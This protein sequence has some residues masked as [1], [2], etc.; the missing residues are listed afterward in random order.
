[1]PSVPSVPVSWGE[2]L[3]KVSI[4][5][6]KRERLPAG[7]GLLNVE[8][9]HALLGA[10]ARE[11]LPREGIA[12]LFEQLRR[13]NRTLWDVEDALR[14][15]EDQARFGPGVVALARSVYQTNDSRAA[16]KRQINLLLE[17]ELVEEKSYAATS[18][19][20]RPQTII[21]E[22]IG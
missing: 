4:L 6:I 7:P 2:L 10:T 13:I 15:R 20:P 17:S 5:E 14:Q 16:I 3:D 8:R 18:P 9:E 12:P 11:V 1:M 21:T 22:R 19:A